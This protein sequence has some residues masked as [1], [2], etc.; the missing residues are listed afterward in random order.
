MGV[1]EFDQFVGPDAEFAA[2]GD[3][4]GNSITRGGE[5]ARSSPLSPINAPTDDLSAC[6]I[7]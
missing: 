5:T 4:I 6:R 7:D 3:G 2:R 1:K